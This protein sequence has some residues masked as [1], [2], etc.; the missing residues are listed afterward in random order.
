ML[1]SFIGVVILL[2]S[3]PT[4][5][6]FAG[7]AVCFL[8]GFANIPG[9]KLWRAG[10]ARHESWMATSGLCLGWLGQSVVSV[11][12]AAVLIQLARLFF[13]H[14]DIWSFFRWLY[15]IAL[16]YL[17]IKPSNETRLVAEN[18]SPEAEKSYYRLTLSLT[19]LT[20]ALAFVTLAIVPWNFLE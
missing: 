2:V 11:L 12:F 17:S 10:T 4:V 5:G 18:S 13:A 8:M 9:Y 3:I 14:F 16:C 6:Y 15:W 20:T 19:I 1:N 7:A